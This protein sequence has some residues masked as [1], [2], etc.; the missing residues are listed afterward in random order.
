LN[1][2]KNCAIIKEKGQ[3]GILLNV[4]DRLRVVYNNSDYYPVAYQLSFADD[5]TVIHT[6]IIHDIKANSILHVP[7]DK[8]NKKECK[9][10]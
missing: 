10:G 3:Y 1:K 5:G 6:A 7:L 4:P 9:N 8:V 2:C